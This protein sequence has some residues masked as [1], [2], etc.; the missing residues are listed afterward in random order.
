MCTECSVDC[1][2]LKVNL[3]DSTMIVVNEKGK[4]SL[5]NSITKVF[6]SFLTL[7]G[8]AHSQR[9]GDDVITLASEVELKLLSGL[10][11]F[12]VTLIVFSCMLI[13][14][15]SICSERTK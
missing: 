1:A 15:I 12:F 9:F 5:C 14:I 6:D 8:R 4:T 13:H 7:N 3:V 11:E 10:S 2:Y